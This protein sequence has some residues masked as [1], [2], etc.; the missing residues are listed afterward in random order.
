MRDYDEFEPK[1][2]NSNVDFHAPALYACL[3]GHLDIF[4]Y[5]VSLMDGVSI[6]A[7]FKNNLVR[8][9]F[10]SVQRV[11]DFP[12]HAVASGGHTHVC[13]FLLDNGVDINHLVHGYSALHIA[14]RRGRADVVQ[15]L[16]SQGADPSMIRVS[17]MN[18]CASGTSTESPFAAAVHYGHTSVLKLLFAFCCTSRS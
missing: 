17:L 2:I 7:M 4:Q 8:N 11:R 15:L 10:H 9:Q 3:Y 16:L 18:I 13:Q 5:L 12:L 1:E 6:E 14:A